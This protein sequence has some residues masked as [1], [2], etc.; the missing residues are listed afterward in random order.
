MCNSHP[1]PG[2]QASHD[3]DSESKRYVVFAWL[4]G[5][6]GELRSEL[7]LEAMERRESESSLSYAVAEADT[8]ELE[9]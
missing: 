7:L 4:L 5:L 8:D 1:R 6:G 9:M 3:P 2:R